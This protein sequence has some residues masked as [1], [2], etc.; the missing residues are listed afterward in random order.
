MEDWD[1]AA[2]PIADLRRTPVRE[3]PPRPDGR[4]PSRGLVQPVRVTDHGSGAGH[5]PTLI[6]PTSFSNRD[7]FCPVRR[8]RGS[9]RLSGGERAH[10][11]VGVASTYRLL[12]A[13]Y[14]LVEPVG[15]RRQRLPWRRSVR[16]SLGRHRGFSSQPLSG[17]AR[18]ASYG[19]PVRL[20]TPAGTTRQANPCTGHAPVAPSSDGGD[21]S[22]EAK[23]AGWDSN[24]RPKD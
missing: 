4:S 6:C 18:K 23:R 2:E 11:P 14:D 8:T 22:S 5:R 10:E 1:Q 19:R 20:E 12:Q 21:S 7:S 13:R 9:S 24:P 17:H 15:V 16:P 3:A